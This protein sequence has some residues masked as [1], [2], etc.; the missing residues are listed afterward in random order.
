MTS[1]KAMK[2]ILA[3]LVFIGLYTS[4][5][6]NAVIAQ[7]LWIEA[8]TKNYRGCNQH[9]MY[10]T[11]D[12][13]Y[14]FN[15][16]FEAASNHVLYKNDYF[17]RGD[18]IFQKP[19]SR[20]VLYTLSNDP[21]SLPDSLKGP[22]LLG[23]FQADSLVLTDQRNRYTRYLKRT[24]STRLSK[25]KKNRLSKLMCDFIFEVDVSPLL[26][27]RGTEVKTIEYKD[28]TNV[29]VNPTDPHYS[30]DGIYFISDVCFLLIPAAKQKFF[31]VID[32]DKRSIL[33]ESLCGKRKQVRLEKTI[34]K[35]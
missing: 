16:G 10:Q 8:G 11:S 2:R 34:K 4:S 12:T 20:K 7:T 1:K 19:L 27:K 24:S 5:V 13:L 25:A 32:V 18:S 31:Q 30:P 17:L 9:M 28:V 6:F 35:K 33:V 26:G 29:K 14:W 21:D 3:G 23:V 15:T 22:F